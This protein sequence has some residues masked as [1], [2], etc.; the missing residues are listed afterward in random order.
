MH[1]KSKAEANDRKGLMLGLF[2]FGLVLALVILPFQFR[3]EAGSKSKG[4][5]RTESIDERLGASYDI[6]EDKASAEKII[7]YREQAGK[8]AYSISEARDN[9]VR[10]EQSLKQRLPHSK[11]EYNQDSNSGSYHP[12]RLE[13]KNRIF[14]FAF[15]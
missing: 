6:R 15:F 2:A 9:F 7:S 5:L 3:S 14:K 8:N 4:L 1:K 11:V 10:G 13:S 12:G